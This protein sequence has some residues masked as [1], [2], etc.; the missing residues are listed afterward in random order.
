MKVYA[1]QYPRENMLRHVIPVMK[2]DGV[3]SGYIAVVEDFC[4]SGYRIDSIDASL[5]G[6]PVEKAPAYLIQ[7]AEN[8]VRLYRKGR[9]EGPDEDN[10]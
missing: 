1:V 5:L 2:I 3:R 9:R 10:G 4:K 7:V 8:L 6:N